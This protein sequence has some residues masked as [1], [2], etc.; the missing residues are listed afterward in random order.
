MIDLQGL[1]DR[2]IPEPNSGCWLWANGLSKFGYADTYYEQAHKVMRAHRV[3]WLLAR[4][5]IPNGLHVLHKCDTRS[6][7]NPDHLF[8]GTNADNVADKMRKGRHRYLS[9]DQ[10]PARRRPDRMARGE[11]HGCAKL[12]E[13]EVAEI[14]RLAA[15]G[16]SKHLLSRRFDVHRRTII[17]IVERKIWRHLP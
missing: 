9:G 16:S 3:A 11:G 8:L 7:V 4:G 10:H 12:T 17:R 14:R 5:P 6:C 1:L 13:I 15:A 2:T